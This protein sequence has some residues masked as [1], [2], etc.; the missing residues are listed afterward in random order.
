MTASFRNTV[1]DL[2]D[3]HVAKA[4]CDKGTCIKSVVQIRGISRY[5]FQMAFWWTL[6]VNFGQFKLPKSI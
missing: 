1:F 5:M 2:C 4:S 3:M 6:G